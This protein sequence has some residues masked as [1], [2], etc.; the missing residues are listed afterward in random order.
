MDWCGY[1]FIFLS[2][3]CRSIEGKYLPITWFYHF[4]CYFSYN[5]LIIAKRIR[6]E[7]AVLEENLDGYIEHKKKV[8]YKMIPY[9]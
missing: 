7:E 3:L 6:N 1:I 2:A 9:C 5:S 4:I 8:K